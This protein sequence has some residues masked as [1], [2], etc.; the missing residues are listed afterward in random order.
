MQ[1]RLHVYP[2][3]LF[4]A[5]GFGSE[6]NVGRISQKHNPVSVCQSIQRRYGCLDAIAQIVLSFSWPSILLINI[7]GINKKNNT[8]SC[9]PKIQFQQNN[10]NQQSY[11]PFIFQHHTITIKLNQSDETTLEHHFNN[12][13]QCL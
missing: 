9:Q 11:F 6:I 12:T 7:T 1:R 8:S 13:Q 5:W 4:T 3:L 2:K 10:K